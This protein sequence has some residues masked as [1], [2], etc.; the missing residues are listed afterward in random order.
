[1]VLGG[2]SVGTLPGVRGVTQPPVLDDVSV[3]VDDSERLIWRLNADPIKVS[4]PILGGCGVRLANARPIG[5]LLFVSHSCY[6]L[7]MRQV[8]S[9]FVLALIHLAVLVSPVIPDVV[10]VAV[11]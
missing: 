6:C 4:C 5:S 10:S 9:D 3:F 1:M 8:K 7:K 2:T 11:L